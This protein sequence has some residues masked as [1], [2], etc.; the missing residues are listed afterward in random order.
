MCIQEKTREGA[1]QSSWRGAWGSSTWLAWRPCGL[2]AADYKV[3]MEMV[4]VMKRRRRRRMF[5]EMAI[6][7]DHHHHT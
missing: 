4:M 3:V 5:V 6:N 7:T 2:H 1:D